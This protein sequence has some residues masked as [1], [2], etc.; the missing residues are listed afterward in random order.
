MRNYYPASWKQQWAKPMVSLYDYV[1]TK[2]EATEREKQIRSL[3]WDF[4]DGKRSKQV[5]ALVANRIA[6]QFGSFAETIVFACIPA[7]SAEKT[8]IR[9]HD[10]CE[11]VSA[12]CGCMNGYNAIKVEGSRMAIHETKAG[13][14]VQ[15]TETITFNADFFNGKRVIIFDDILTKGRSYAQFA[16]AIEQLGAEVLGG[17]F[18]GK[19]THYNSNN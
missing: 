12:L 1:P 7:S 10:F 18:L 17:L 19:T 2:Y 15:N 8:E 9:Y 4:K 16:T 13:K 5:A 3:V 11:Q 6:Q 14:N